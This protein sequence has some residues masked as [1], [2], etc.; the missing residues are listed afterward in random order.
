MAQLLLATGMTEYSN[1]AVSCRVSSWTSGRRL[2]FQPQDRMESGSE[3]ENLVK[4]AITELFEQVLIIVTTVETT[5]L[6]RGREDFRGTVLTFRLK[7][8]ENAL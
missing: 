6:S 2:H 1:V 3:S 8:A 7:N 4:I 5:R